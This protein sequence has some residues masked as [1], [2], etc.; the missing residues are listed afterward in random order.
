MI[1]NMSDTMKHAVSI[2]M[3]L[4]A[5]AVSSSAQ[6]VQ[7]EFSAQRQYDV[8]F[9][10]ADMKYAFEDYKGS[11]NSWHR[12]FY[13]DLEAL[14]GLDRLGDIYKDFVPYAEQ[15]DCEDLGDITRERWQVWTEP[16]MVIPFVLLRPKGEINN[17]PLIITPQ[18]HDKN[19]E[20]YF[21][22]YT[23][24]SDDEAS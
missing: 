6:D 9:E 2:L 15:L 19:P 12:K 10:Q 24:D 14:L 7:R 8:Q 11:H 21:G 1:V 23:D 16:T 18:G 4:L 20:I 22:I 5:V 3:L 17:R 13:K